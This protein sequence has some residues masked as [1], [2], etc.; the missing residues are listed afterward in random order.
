[1]SPLADT[2]G[3]LIREK[4]SVVKYRQCGVAMVDPITLSWHP[5]NFNVTPFVTGM[6]E[7]PQVVGIR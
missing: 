1:V 6:L 5:S 4:S 7:V 2:V 3:R